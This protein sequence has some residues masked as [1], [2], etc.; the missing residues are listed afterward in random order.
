[1]I[2]LGLT[3]SIGMGK[4]TTAALFAEVGCAVWDADNAVHR[5]YAKT[6][7]AVRPIQKLFPQAIKNEQVS[8]DILRQIIAEDPSALPK[9]EAIVHPLVALDRVEFARTSK[10]DIIVF[11]IPLLFENNLEQEFDKVVCVTVNPA[12]QRARV[13]ARNSM[14]EADF[15]RLLSFQMPDEEKRRKADY[16]ITTET[17]ESTRLQVK[18]I[19][20]KVKTDLMNA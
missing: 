7:S 13:L 14:T 2:R 20:E 18:K 1:M 4:S 16:V 10:K 9:I 11:D 15:K 6:G 8:R 12:E 5:L 3:G 17:V 19:L